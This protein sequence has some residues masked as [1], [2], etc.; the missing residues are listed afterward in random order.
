MTTLE[1]EILA[2]RNHKFLNWPYSYALKNIDQ[3]HLGS[4]RCHLQLEAHFHVRR[5][6]ASVRAIVHSDYANFD[7]DS[8]IRAAHYSFLIYASVRM[9][10][11]CREFAT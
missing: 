11:V 8:D 5:W 2:L 3:R 4:L 10:T 1:A 7:R 6:I 9:E